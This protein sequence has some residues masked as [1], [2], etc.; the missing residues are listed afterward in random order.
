MCW[1]FLVE[2]N[3]FELQISK[4]PNWLTEEFVWIACIRELVLVDTEE[5]EES[6]IS[7]V[8]LLLTNMWGKIKQFLYTK[9]CPKCIKCLLLYIWSVTSLW[10]LVTTAR[11]RCCR[12]LFCSWDKVYIS[13][14][15][16]RTNY[17]SNWELQFD[18]IKWTPL[19]SSFEES[20]PEHCFIFLPLS[21]N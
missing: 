1:K 17:W 10:P 3:F 19:L 15:Y 4:K 21:L 9:F 14:K 7:R 8:L 6:L 11:V 5:E 13:I 12:G 20:R 16:R 2:I 18:Q